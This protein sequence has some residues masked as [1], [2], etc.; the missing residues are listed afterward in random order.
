MLTLIKN[1]TQYFVASETKVSSQCIRDII[2]WNNIVESDH[3]NSSKFFRQFVDNGDQLTKLLKFTTGFSILSSFN[4][5]TINLEAEA[6]F[7][8]LRLATMHK[9][10]EEFKRYIDIAFNQGSEG[11]GNILFLFSFHTIH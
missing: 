4:R 1:H 3:A 11:C 9:F 2:N 10:F 7:S 8:I 5:T 6:C